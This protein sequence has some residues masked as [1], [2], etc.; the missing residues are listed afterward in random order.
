MTSLEAVY[1]I[2]CS[3]LWCQKRLI[4]TFCTYAVVLYESCKHTLI[5]KVGGVI[6]KKKR[7]TMRPFLVFLSFC[8]E[9]N[10]NSKDMDKLALINAN[11]LISCKKKK[12][13]I[14]MFFE[15]TP[16]TVYSLQLAS[17]M[18]LKSTRL[19]S[20][21]C[22]YIITIQWHFCTIWNCF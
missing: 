1:Q 13:C 9:V 8:T 17:R 22:I 4:T 7:Y 10:T 18:I 14:V 5:S 19:K 12:K 11:L 21:Y 6:L 20:R 16:G 15:P 2:T 3:F